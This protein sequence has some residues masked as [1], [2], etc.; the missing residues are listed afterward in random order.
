MGGGVQ[1][2]GHVQFL[3]NH[4]VFGMDV[5]AAID[6]PRFRHYDRL[7]VAL[8]APVTDSVRAALAAMGHVLID[9][10]PIAFGGAQA[11][12]RLPKGYAAG[13]DPRK[14]GMAVGY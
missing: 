6:A 1:A 11:I 13:S 4:F 12:I 7:R 2:Q 9:Q 10:P 5:Q 14:D 8:E 3:L